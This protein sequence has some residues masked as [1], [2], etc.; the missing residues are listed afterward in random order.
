MLPVNN[1][2]SKMLLNVKIF[3]EF[4]F[5]W[6]HSVK[7]YHIIRSQINPNFQ[8]KDKTMPYTENVLFRPTLV[9]LLEGLL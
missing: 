7:G 5:I 1:K 2:C 9:S 4:F 8:K 6:F 3:Y